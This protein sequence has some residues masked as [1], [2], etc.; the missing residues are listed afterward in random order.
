MDRN[1]TNDMLTHLQPDHHSPPAG[2]NPTTAADLLLL[3]TWETERSMHL[4]IMLRV[5]QIRRANPRPTASGAPR[6]I[7]GWID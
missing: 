4:G 5:R 7:C 2:D 1:G 3:K 6:A